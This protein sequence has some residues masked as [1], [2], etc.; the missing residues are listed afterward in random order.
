MSHYSHFLL[1]KQAQAQRDMLVRIAK[2]IGD[3]ARIWLLSLALSITT[4]KGSEEKEG[5]KMKQDQRLWWAALCAT[6]AEV[7]GLYSVTI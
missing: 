4:R 7:Q 1:S 6:V 2:L 3:G 5:G